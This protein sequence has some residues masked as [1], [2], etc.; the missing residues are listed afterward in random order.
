MNTCTAFELGV[1]HLRPKASNSVHC[2]FIAVR[3]CKKQLITK[4]Y[5]MYNEILFTYYS[6][7]PSFTE[8]TN[9]ITLTFSRGFNHGKYDC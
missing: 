4:Q 6:T 2:S 1:G 9:I 3:F 5:E 7:I 8:P